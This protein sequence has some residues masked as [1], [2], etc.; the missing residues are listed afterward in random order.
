[1]YIFMNTQKIKTL[2]AI[3]TPLY[4]QNKFKMLF[5]E[6]GKNSYIINPFQI[7][8]PK[9][10]TIYNNVYIGGGSTLSCFNGQLKI[11][12]NTFVTRSLNI[13]CGEKI[14]IED[15]VLIASY[16]LITD[17]SHGINPELKENYQK[18][19]ITTKPVFIGKGCWIGDK[20]S[21]LP[22]SHIGEKSVIAAN[23]VVRGIIPAYSMV[24]GNPAII[25]KS[26]DFHK[27]IW[28]KQV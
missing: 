20:A 27:N 28:I 9:N 15:D 25:I 2:L 19:Q 16:V 14:I 11:G 17:L 6:K 5:I 13:Y 22:G 10:I 12:N 23:S 4:L 8:Q 26:W 7:N 21:I 18:Q 3:Y 24:S 1:M